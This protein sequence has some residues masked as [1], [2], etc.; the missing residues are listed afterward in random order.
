MNKITRLMKIVALL[1]YKNSPEI[2][3]LL[4]LA[5]VQYFG[6]FRINK[7]NFDEIIKILLQDLN[8][9]FGYTINEMKPKIIH[10]STSIITRNTSMIDI[11][12]CVSSIHEDISNKTCYDNLPIKTKTFEKESKDTGISSTITVASIS[13]PSKFDITT[14]ENKKKLIL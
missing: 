9:E 3:N 14:N 12:T 5:D 11:S 1:G 6:K 2:L 8:K 13:S 10:T 4:I 7:L